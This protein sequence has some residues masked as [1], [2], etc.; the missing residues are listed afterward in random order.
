[1]L[2]Q[3]L[4]FPLFFGVMLIERRRILRRDKADSLMSEIGEG[5]TYEESMCS[6][7][8]HYRNSFDMPINILKLIF[9]IYLG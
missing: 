3:I 5:C 9:V 1:M 8:L 2:E 4:I 6:L 7:I